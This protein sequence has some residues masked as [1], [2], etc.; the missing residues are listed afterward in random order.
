MF[1][2]FLWDD[3]KT[4]PISVSQK[5]YRFLHVDS[6]FEPIVKVYNKSDQKI[7][8]RKLHNLLY[9]E[10]AFNMKMGIKSFIGNSIYDRITLKYRRKNI[11]KIDVKILDE[12]RNNLKEFFKSDI[13][14]I[15]RY[16][17]KDLS[18]WKN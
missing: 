3:L 11:S 15:E 9:N 14:K 5:C 13:E 6:S 1:L 7:K 2:L 18:V 10:R 4:N 8:F 17:D 16:L 12:T